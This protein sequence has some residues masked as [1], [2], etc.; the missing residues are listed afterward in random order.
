M[1]NCSTCLGS[2]AP[3]TRAYVRPRGMKSAVEL[4][5][6]EGLWA[7][8][9]SGRVGDGVRERGRMDEVRDEEDA[10]DSERG[11]KGGNGNL[12]AFGDIGDIGRTRRSLTAVLIRCIVS[13]RAA[14]VRNE[15]FKLA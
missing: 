2:I 5:G 13:S 7:S 11:V 6:V 3:R 9:E 12:D 4:A 14:S 8:S 1:G 10:G 15:N